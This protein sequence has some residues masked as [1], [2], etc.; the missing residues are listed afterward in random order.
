[1]NLAEVVLAA[2]EVQDFLERRKWPFCIIGGL[3]IQR[4]GEARF[5]ND[6]D[7]TLLTGF[8]KEEFYI[9]ELLASFPARR[10]DARTFALERRVLLLQTSKEIGVDIAMGAFPFEENSI[11]RSS[12]WEFPLGRKLRTCSAE[13]LVVH[14]VFAGRFR[15]WADVENILIRQLQSLDLDLIRRE[16]KPLLQLKEETESLQKL[17]D[18]I[19]KV[20]QL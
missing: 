13:D 16:L 19:E 11:K 6:V 14:K 7:I 12:Y 15:D 1:M 9:D 5:T 4:W 20:R 18:L 10:P 2:V 8:G 17:D 3:A